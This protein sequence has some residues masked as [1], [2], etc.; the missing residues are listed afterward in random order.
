MGPCDQGARLASSAVSL[1]LRAGSCPQEAR[2]AIA[3]AGACLSELVP[4]YEILVI[5]GEEHEGAALAIQEGDARDPRVR[6]VS[7]TGNDWGAALRQG[8]SL[9]RFPL[10]AIA[11]AGFDLGS[12]DYLVPLA[13]RFPVVCGARRDP[14]S[15]AR[16]RLARWTYSVLCR[17]LLGSGV[18][19]CDSGLMVLRRDVLDDLLPDAGY[20]FPGAEVLLRA[21]RRGLAV[22]E[23]PVAFHGAVVRDRGTRLRDWPRIFLSFLSFWWSRFL[24]PG[25]PPATLTAGRASWLPG[26]LLLALAS[27]LLFSD[28]NQPLLDPD[29]GRQAEVPREMLAHNDWL[30]PRMLGEPYYEKPPLPY[31]LTACSYRIFGIHSWS[32]RLVPALAAWLAVLLT[33]MWGRAVLGARAAFL[34]GVGLCLSLGFIT[35]GRTVVPDSLLTTCVVASWLA[36]HRAVAGPVL[37]WRWWLL[38][39]SACGLGILAKGPVAAVLVVAPVGAYQLLTAGSCRPRLHYWLAYVA[40]VLVLAAPW[41]V[42]MA[43][44]QPQFLGEFLWKANVR[45]FVDPYDHQQPWWFY[46]PVLFIATLPWS[47]LLIWLAYFLSSQKRRIV[48]LRPSGLG[49]CVLTAGWSFL[50]FSLAGCKSPLYIAPVFAPLA[51]MLGVCL[52]AILFRQVGHNDEFLRRARQGLPRRAAL[53]VLALST[54]CFLLTGI[55]RWEQGV[56]VGFEVAVTGAAMAVWWRYGRR[57]SAKWSW[58]VCAAATLVLVA[59]AARDLVVG[60]ASRHTVQ[61]VAAVA[62]RWSG[63]SRPVVSYGRQW[64][65][66]SFY[67]RRESVAFVSENARPELIRFLQSC[68][69]ALVLVERGPLLTD[70]LHA[71]PADLRTEVVLPEKEGQAALLL[72]QH[73]PKARY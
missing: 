63:R 13:A 51:L 17:G 28:L 60:V 61:E 25:S 65:S 1:I 73:R 56:V 72:V 38:S 41:Y 71:L 9:A 52:D 16:T 29:E 14:R 45:R 47:L 53:A 27:L 26:L 36:A 24:F 33:Y 67:L 50:F 40:A 57:A 62:R 46:G 12:L 66:A 55:L 70:L 31:W 49:F 44:T 3:R 35:M 22:A 39:A 5:G 10:V 68:P 15:P 30:L 11:D 54:G 69:E 8:A 32:A 58:A 6:F 21:R 59:V 20:P 34:G 48:L 43:V 23:V 37:R 4:D 18:R 2:E 19:D 64:P 42:A 7:R